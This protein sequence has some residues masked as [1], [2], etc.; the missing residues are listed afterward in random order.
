MK[1][2]WNEEQKSEIKRW[3][4]SIG[5][6]QEM[7]ES[8]DFIANV[9]S[10]ELCFDLVA[11]EHNEGEYKLSTDLYVGGSE[12]KCGY[13]TS[14]TGKPYDFFG[15]VGYSFKSSIFKDMKVKQFK[16]FIEEQLT[17]IIT[18]ANPSCSVGIMGTCCNLFE[19]A[20]KPL[21]EW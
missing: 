2:T 9:R 1:W 6:Q 3:L 12:I 8:F 19:K 16:Q 14:A 11:R 20:N 18:D 13:G 15:D 17:Q 4:Q 10:G 5:T 21:I 7:D